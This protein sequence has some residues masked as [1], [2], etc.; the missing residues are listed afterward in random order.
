VERFVG[1]VSV[2]VGV[3]CGGVKVVVVCVSET[4]ITIGLHVDGSPMSHAPFG[5]EVDDNIE[6]GSD[7]GNVVGLV[8]VGSSPSGLEGGVGCASVTPVGGDG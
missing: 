5:T 6:V 8:G 3:R 4:V 2:C 1:D 7:L